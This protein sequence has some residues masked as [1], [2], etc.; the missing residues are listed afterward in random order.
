MVEIAVEAKVETGSCLLF[1]FVSA[2]IASTLAVSAFSRFLFS[3]ASRLHRLQ[4]R[5]DHLVKQARR[6]VAKLPEEGFAA[7]ADKATAA[8]RAVA[9]VQD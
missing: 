6:V 4:S 8:A 3:F 2:G 7:S 5:S 9:V 1:S